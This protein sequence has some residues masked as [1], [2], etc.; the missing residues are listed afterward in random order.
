ME[1]SRI[2]GHWTG[3]FTAQGRRTQIEFTECVTA[4]NPLM[5]PFIKLYLQRQ[6]AQFVQDL[7]REL[8]AQHR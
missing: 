5:K 7:K 3:L 2:R 6:Q 8:E 1:N 4:K